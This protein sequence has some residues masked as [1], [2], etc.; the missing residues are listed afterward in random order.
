MR[1]IIWLAVVGLSLAVTAGAARA[2]AWQAVSV[3][4]AVKDVAIWGNVWILGQNNQVYVWGGAGWTPHATPLRD[5]VSIEVG[6]DQRPFVN[7]GA[8]WTLYKSNGSGWSALPGTGVSN[9]GVD[10][11]SY[12]WS[13][14]GSARLFQYFDGR[15][16]QRGTYGVGSSI[17]FN[18]GGI[19][20]AIGNDG[21][22]YRLMN[23]QL[24]RLDGPLCADLDI[25]D[26]SYVW[27]VGKGDGRVHRQDGSGWATYQ[28]PGAVQASRI[29][30]TGAGQPYVVGNDGQLYTCPGCAGGGAPPPQTTNR[31]PNAPTVPAGTWDPPLTVAPGGSVQLAWRNNG[32]PDGDA[33]TFGVY[34]QQHDPATQ[35]WIPS[36]GFSDAA[37]NPVAV[38]M[39][40]TSYSFT[41]QPG[42]Y[43]YW[44]VIVCEVGRTADQPCLASGWSWFRTR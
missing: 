41:P 31:P 35:R 33:L 8:T 1:R 20:G 15:A 29:A 2:Q 14:L 7:G 13:S 19:A 27:T 23:G 37:G 38:W 43:Y 25:D 10:A 39:T 17:T 40:G 30:V 22:A 11:R 3:P 9:L 26:R 24:R 21:L 42:T 5:L 16:W 6:P 44:Q 18:A 28:L 4:T 32:D 36:P 12:P 34:V